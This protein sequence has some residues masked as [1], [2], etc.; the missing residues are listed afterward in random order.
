MY[1]GAMPGMRSMN[2][3]RM[4][5]ART[6][7][8]YGA[9]ADPRVR[10]ERSISPLDLF[11]LVLAQQA[12]GPDHEDE[13]D[14]RERDGVAKL[15]HLEAHDAVDD[16]EQQSANDRAGQAGQPADHRR[17]EGLERDVAHHAGVQV[18]QR[19]D[20]HAGHRAGGRA[21]APAE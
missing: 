17:G 8:P 19:G 7:S 3:G 6:A 16:A 20:Q 10:S 9:T 1:P 21:E 14:E 15:G 4:S 12:T 11:R 2:V 5:T 18:V 13:D